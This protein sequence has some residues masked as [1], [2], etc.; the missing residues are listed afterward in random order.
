MLVVESLKA[1]QKGFGLEP[2][3]IR[4]TEGTCKRS[5]L[6]N[7]QIIAAW[8]YSQSFLPPCELPGPASHPCHHMTSVTACELP[9]HACWSVP[10]L[11]QPMPLLT[12][13]SFPAVSLV[14][15]L[16]LVPCRWPHIALTET[17]APGCSQ[18][19]SLQCSLLRGTICNHHLLAQ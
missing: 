3:S 13:S 8:N 5:E 9:T 10:A 6:I 16:P 2:R 18:D 1:I 12:S 19:S 17:L 4:T 14:W 15:Y 7:P 11:I